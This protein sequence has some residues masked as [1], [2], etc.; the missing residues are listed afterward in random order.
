[1]R[2][3]EHIHYVKRCEKNSL[4]TFQL[5]DTD[6]TAVFP[7]GG[8]A[9]DGKELSEQ[10]SFNE[11]P[12]LWEDGLLQAHWEQGHCGKTENLLLFL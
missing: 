9:S 5:T 2:K 6:R 3:P 8:M 1:M 7:T 11:S 12:P 10:L 4:S